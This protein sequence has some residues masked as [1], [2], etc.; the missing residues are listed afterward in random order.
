M[1]LLL[2]DILN[3]A[4]ARFTRE[5]CLTPRLDAELLFCHML[6][7]DKS[8]LFL[9]YGDELDDKICEEY[10]RLVDIRAGGMPLQYITGSQEFMGLPFR[11]NEKVLIPRQDTEILVE[12]A[13]EILKARKETRGGFR[14]LDLCCGSGAI[15][16][17]LAYYLKKA[18]RKAAVLGSDISSDALEVAKENA[19]INGVD[20]QI[21]FVEGDLFGPFPKNRKDRGRKQFD[22]IVCNPPYIPTGVLPTLMREVREHEPLLALDGGEDGLDFYRRILEEAWRYLVEEGVL[23]LE[24]G[25]DQGI[26]VPLLAE[27]AGAYGPVEIIKDLAGK[28]R[29]AV[30]KRNENADRSNVKR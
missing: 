3:M 30:I 5:G 12:K 2:K 17:S 24:I 16:V 15:A 18:K 27:E 20:R 25:Y 8:W 7:K 4:E 6:K 19:R 23:L 1:K 9:H 21:R 13:L 29:V 14:I 28:D 10:F 22:M 26:T 11:V